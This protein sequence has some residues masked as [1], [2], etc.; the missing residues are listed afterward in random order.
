MNGGRRR[1]R[2][3]SG[4]SKNPI[5]RC[6]EQPPCSLQ[7]D[8][9]FG[10]FDRENQP[11]NWASKS[12]GENYQGGTM[13]RLQGKTNRLILF[14]HSTS[15]ETPSTCF[16]GRVSIPRQ[17]YLKVMCVVCV[18]VHGLLRKPGISFELHRTWTGIKHFGVSNS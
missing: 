4:K 13:P 16:T 5:Q 14:G 15:K 11:M 1:A 7:M 6:G 9:L 2:A 12:T 10:K 8:T 18:C 3:R 17:S